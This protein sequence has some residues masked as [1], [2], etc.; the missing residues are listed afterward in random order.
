MTTII[1][2]AGRKQSGKTTCS[3]FVANYHNGVLPPFNG[4]KVYNFADCLKKDICINILGLTHDQCYGDDVSKN[5]YTEVYW[6]DIRLTAREVMQLVGTDIFRKMK[7][8]VWVSSTIN[9][10]LIEKP[11]LALIA[12]CRFPNEVEA[13]RDQGGIVIKLTR[14]PYNS[15]H[16]SEVSLDTKN[17]DQSNFDLIIDNINISIPEQNNIILKFL[18]AKGVLK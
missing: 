8:D 15:D 12:D 11:N 10:I 14:N 9:K 3:E 2:F 5:Q 4:A 18:R 13:I 16:S 1:G 6:N 17:Y 7:K